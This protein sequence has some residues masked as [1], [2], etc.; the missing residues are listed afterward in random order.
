M[1]LHPRPDSMWLF[2]LL[3]L[4]LGL[5]MAW[6]NAM[7]VIDDFNRNQ[8]P[9]ESW[10]PYLWEYS[11]FVVIFG[12]YFAVYWLARMCPLISPQWQKNL[13]IHGLA[14]VVF[15]LLHVLLMVMIRKMVYAWMGGVYDFGDWSHELWYEYRKDFFTYFIFLLLLTAY[16]YWQAQ[17]HQQQINTVPKLKVKNQQGVHW[18]AFTDINRIES[19]GNYVYVHAGDQVLPMR[20]TMAEIEQQLAPDDFIRV[21]RSYIINS[22]H[23]KAVTDRSKDPCTVVLLNGKKIPVSRKYRAILWQLMGLVDD[24]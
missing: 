12:L 9:Y 10:Q 18:I 2:W 20:A 19:G 6:L 16:G 17:Q 7:T 1:K 3:V 23:I 4:A 22:A 13:L 5:L 14:T 11:S 8:V 24:R 21:H 15:S